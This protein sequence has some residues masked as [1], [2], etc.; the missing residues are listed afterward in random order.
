MKN[1]KKVKISGKFE[2]NKFGK[3]SRNYLIFNLISRIFLRSVDMAA[4]PTRLLEI[5]SFLKHFSHKFI[6]YVRNILDL[7]VKWPGFQLNIFKSFVS[8]II[9]LLLFV[10]K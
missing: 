10:H 8:L 4:A 1:S 2:D 3:F 7:F 9:S 6:T 5:I